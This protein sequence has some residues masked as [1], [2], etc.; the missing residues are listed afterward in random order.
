[1]A[2]EFHRQAAQRLRHVTLDASDRRLSESNAMVLLRDLPDFVD[3]ALA[4]EFPRRQ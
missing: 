4:G 1:L 3:A 2:V